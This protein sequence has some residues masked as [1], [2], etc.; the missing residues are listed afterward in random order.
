MTTVHQ[1]NGARVTGTRSHATSTS[2][3]WNVS[4]QFEL[5]L[6]AIKKSLATGGLLD[7]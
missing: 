5:T 7:A 4:P 3:A 2:E 6:S 1:V